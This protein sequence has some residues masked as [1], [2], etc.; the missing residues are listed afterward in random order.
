MRLRTYTA[1]PIA[2]IGQ[3]RVEVRYK[4]YAGSHVLTVV[5]GKGP[6]LLGWDWLSCIKLDWANIRRVGAQI[7]MGTLDQLLSQYARVFSKD[8]GTMKHMRA[9]LTLRYGAIPRVHSPRSAP[10]AIRDMVGRELERLEE[11]GVIR[12]VNHATWAAP[13]V[14]VPKKMALCGC[15]E[16]LRSPSTPFCWLTCTRY[17]NLLTSW[18]ASLGVCVL[19]N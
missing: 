5:Q 3:A 10:Y 19:A 14:P 7:D 13:L 18:L 8:P 9:H 4:E 15:V 17:P 11:T 6:P 12:K 16:I 2:V 1:Q